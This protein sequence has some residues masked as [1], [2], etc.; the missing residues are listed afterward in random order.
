MKIRIIK[1]LAGSTK[2]GKEYDLELSAAKQMISKGIAEEIKE[3][4]KKKPRKKKVDL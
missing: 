4:P 2:K 3:E 1:D